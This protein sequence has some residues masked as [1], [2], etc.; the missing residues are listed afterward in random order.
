[1]RRTYHADLRL[2]NDSRPAFPT[3]AHRL[4]LTAFC[5]LLSLCPLWLRAS[6]PGAVIDG[7]SFI[8]C[9]FRGVR[10]TEVVEAS[11]SILFRNVRIEPAEKGRNLNSRPSWP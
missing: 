9:I 8:D 7:V 10:T 4:L 3:S 1:M 11:G 6:F 2:G 5:P